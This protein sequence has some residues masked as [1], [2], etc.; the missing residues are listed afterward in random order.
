MS[1]WQQL[2]WGNGSFQ[3]HGRTWNTLE[4]E[5]SDKI[6][7]LQ[8]ELKNNQNLWSHWCITHTF[9]FFEVKHSLFLFNVLSDPV[10]FS[11]P[12]TQRVLSPASG[13]TFPL[14]AL[15][16]SPFLCFQS[17]TIKTLSFFKTH[18]KCHFLH[19]VSYISSAGLTGRTSQRL[20][21][22]TLYHRC[23]A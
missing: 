14:L 15:L 4:T 9:F 20:S 13:P 16:T 6:R 2:P 23:D 3:G 17:Y 11:A 19:E 10:L 5:Q 22:A 18:V 1:S 8:R 7:V 21:L 12:Q